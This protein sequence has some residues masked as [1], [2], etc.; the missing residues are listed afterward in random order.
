MSFC[1]AYILSHELLHSDSE[2]CLEGT[3]KSLPA[4]TPDGFIRADREEAEEAPIF[5]RKRGLSGQG[6]R[7]EQFTLRYCS[8]SQSSTLCAASQLLQTELAWKS[9]C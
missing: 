2:S 9:I 7:G 3:L 4:G 5:V 6:L 1:S 8:C